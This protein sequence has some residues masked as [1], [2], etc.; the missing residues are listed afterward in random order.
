MSCNNK[1]CSECYVFSIFLLSEDDQEEIEFGEHKPK[2][3]ITTTPIYLTENQ[4]AI[5]LKY[6]DNNRKRIKPEKAHEIN[7][8]YN[9]QYSDKDTLVL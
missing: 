6:F 9:L 7:A 5:Q 8:R 4:P 3:K 2:E 1:W